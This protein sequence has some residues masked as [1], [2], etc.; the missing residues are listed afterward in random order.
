MNPLGLT[1]K[2]VLPCLTPGCFLAQLNPVALLMVRRAGSGCVGDDTIEMDLWTPD[3]VDVMVAILP[4]SPQN[5]RFLWFD[6]SMEWPASPYKPGDVVVAPDGRLWF[7]G[8]ETLEG[9]VQVLADWDVDEH[10]FLMGGVLQYGP[11]SLE[12]K[13]RLERV[14]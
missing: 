2:E 13:T 6:R 7:A 4:L 5:F 1:S 10:S 3:K 14:G 9:K 8:P 12:P 11:P